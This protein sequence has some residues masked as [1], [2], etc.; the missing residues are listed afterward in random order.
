MVSK[1]LSVCLSVCLFVC[2]FDL[3]NS[4]LGIKLSIYDQEICVY[5]H[6]TVC[7]QQ[8]WCFFLL[9]LSTLYQCT[10]I[11]LT[12]AFVSLIYFQIARK[13]MSH[14]SVVA[15]MQDSKNP[16]LY[17]LIIKNI[18]YKLTIITFLWFEFDS[19]MTQHQRNLSWVKD[20][21]MLTFLRRASFWPPSMVYISVINTQ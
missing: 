2:L 14:P 17:Y 10:S 7:T 20:F 21:F 13:M 9:F 15:G 19:D 8:E 6:I 18:L 1:N 16:K 11:S 12:I 4:H 5:V 3:E